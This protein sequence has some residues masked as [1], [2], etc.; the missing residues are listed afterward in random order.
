MNISPSK[1]T[2]DNLMGS[3]DIE[4]RP[5]NYEKYRDMEGELES[6]QIIEFIKSRA[7]Q[8]KRSLYENVLTS[9]FDVCI[10]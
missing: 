8:Y 7:V 1:I 10:S 6:S 2:Q 9:L 3:K 5:L 4:F